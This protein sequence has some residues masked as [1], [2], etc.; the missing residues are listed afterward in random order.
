MYALD[1][2][3]ALLL[4]GAMP[5]ASRKPVPLTPL[6]LPRHVSW[7]GLSPRERR[8]VPPGLGRVLDL[9]QVRLINRHHPVS[10]LTRLMGKGARIVV[11]RADI[12]WPDCP[13]E[14][15]TDAG[16]LSLLAHELIHVWQYSRGMTGLGYLWR[17]R[18]CY[19]YALKADQPYHAYGYEQQA[20]MM[21]DWVRLKS[22]L[23]PRHARAEVS[24]DALAQVIDLG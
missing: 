11:R 20:A 9:T 23:A 13:D 17:E 8:A 16:A 15:S 10:H 19:D 2:G 6:P 1:L 3:A 5:A 21:E 14:I 22:K 24:A 12:W 4:H 18:G 7:R